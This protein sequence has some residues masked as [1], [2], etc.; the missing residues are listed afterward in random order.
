MIRSLLHPWR[1]GIALIAVLLLL[2]EALNAVPAL[3]TQKIVDEHLTT[4]VREGLFTLALVYYGALVAMSVV[5]V[6]ALYRIAVVAQGALH[7]LRVRLFAHL[8]ALPMSYFDQVPMGD[9]ISRGT[10]DVE[11]VD[12]LF[13]AGAPV[14]LSSLFSLLTTAA[15][16][17][18][19][20]LPLSLVTA[21]I[22]PLLLVIT[23]FFRRR[24][25]EAERANRVAT[26]LMNT[27]LQETLSGQ[28]VIRA[29]RREPVFVARFRDALR[30]L[31]A[32]YNRSTVYTSFYPPLMATLS[33]CLVALLLWLGASGLGEAAMLI[34]R[35]RPV[36]A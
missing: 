25:R 36:K 19:L 16:M 23:Q 27:H 18:L 8:Q 13:S 26:G 17:L 9:I 24:V 22:V 28:E 32:A 15:A 20:S 14:F 6:V 35:A 2:A 3:I 7:A 4:G 29:F 5:M 34:D 10:A 30:Q 21:L 1:F 12:Q 33:A 11:T 31:V